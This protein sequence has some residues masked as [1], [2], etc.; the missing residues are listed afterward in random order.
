M[1]WPVNDKG[2]AAVEFRRGRSLWIATEDGQ[3]IRMRKVYDAEDRQR[4][5]R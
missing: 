1:N 4:A 5:G 2:V 3:S